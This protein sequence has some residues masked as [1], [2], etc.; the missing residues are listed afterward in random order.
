MS[1]L[2]TKEFHKPPSTTYFNENF[3]GIVADFNLKH[4]VLLGLPTRIN[5]SEMC[6]FCFTSIAT[7]LLN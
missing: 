2:P 1:D 6:E 7:H 3:L 5:I 4:T